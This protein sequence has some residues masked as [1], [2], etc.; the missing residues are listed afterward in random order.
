M[1]DDEDPDVDEEEVDLFV[2]PL[3]PPTLRMVIIGFED[4][5]VLLPVLWLDDEHP[6]LPP[7][8]L[9]PFFNVSDVELGSR[10]PWTP[11]VFLSTKRT[12]LSR[13]FEVDTSLV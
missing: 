6:T 8:P 4:I 1:A 5:F 13:L 11:L 2:F 12:L 9:V 3:L 7:L 10:R